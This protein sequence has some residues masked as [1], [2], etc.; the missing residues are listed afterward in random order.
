MRAR[1]RQWILPFLF[2][3]AAAAAAAADWE[4]VAERRAIAGNP[5]LHQS[6]WRALVGERAQEEVFAPLARWFQKRGN[7]PPAPAPS[8]IEKLVSR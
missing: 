5:D 4:A 6:V 1:T 8:P 2:S 7:C 3:V